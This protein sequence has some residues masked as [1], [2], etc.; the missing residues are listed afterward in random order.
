[1]TRFL[2]F[3]TPAKRKK[4]PIFFLYFFYKCSLTNSFEIIKVETIFSWQMS[5]IFILFFHFFYSFY[6]TNLKLASFSNLQ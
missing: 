1:M 3:H 5:I 6:H 4:L 2:N